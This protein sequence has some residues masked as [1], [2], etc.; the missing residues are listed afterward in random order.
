[1]SLF[2]HPA[3]RVADFVCGILALNMLLLPSGATDFSTVNSDKLNHFEAAIAAH[4]RPVTVVSFG[5]SMADSYQSVTYHLMNR[6][7]QRFGNAG[8]S[9]NNYRNTSLWRLENGSVNRGPDYYW[10]CEYFGIPPGGALWWAND[11]NPTGV[12]CDRAGIFYI[13][14]TNGGPFRLLL[15][16]NGAPWTTVMNLNGYNGSP[17][18]HFASLALPLNRYRL[19][20]EGDA[21]T[22]FIIGASTVATQTNG[23][24]TVFI[25]RFGIGL[26]Q[27]TNVP[28]AIRA[29][30]FAALRPDLLIWHMK[31]DGSNTTSNRMEECEAW[32]RAA[33]PDCDIVYIGTPWVSLDT[34]SV[35]TQTQNACVRNIALRHH[36]TYADLM[37]PTIS[38][39][40]LVAQ[41]FM[42]DETHLNSAGGLHGANIM[43]DDLGF[44]ALGLDRRISLQRM[45][46]QLQ[47]SYTTTTSARY[48]LE[49]STNLQIWSAVVTNPGATAS[50]TT[51][52][53]PAAAATFYRLGLTPP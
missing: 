18:G 43:W 50:F 28:I 19:R 37:Q 32:W 3:K 13:S 38:Y 47:L 2:P 52:F 11:L 22:N 46:A 25:E 34:N 51:N 1:M 21:G 42:T 7:N 39:N 53:V 45:G 23:I 14:Q 4:Q 24:H 40:W 9:L 5:D 41:N 27:V 10:F 8:Y 48:R 31:E 20:V 12:L 6:L 16:T 29:P 30:V 26:N 35:L 15:S 17:T 36:R 49:S 33:A 44:F